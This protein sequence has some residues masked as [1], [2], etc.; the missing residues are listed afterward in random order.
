[1]RRR[2]AR[3]M[4]LT[5]RQASGDRSPMPPEFVDSIWRHWDKGTTRAILA[6]YR[7]ADP[8]RLAAAGK[9]LGRLDCPALVL[10]GDRDPY[11]PAGSPPP[12]ADALPKLE[13][14]ARPSRRPLA[15]DRRPELIDQ[16]LDFLTDSALGGMDR[17]PSNGGTRC[18]SMTSRC[19]AQ[20]HPACRTTPFLPP[21]T[22]DYNC[23]VSRA[24]PASAEAA[25]GWGD[26]GRQLGILV[27]VDVAYELVRGIADGQRADGDR[28]RRTGDRLRA[29]DPHLLRAQPA[30][31]LP[32]RPLADRRR[33][34]ALPQRPVLDRARLPDLALPL[35]QRVLLLRPQHVRRL[36]GP[37]SGRLH[38]LPD[39]AAADVP[40]ARL[41]RHDRRL[42]QRQPRLDPGEDLHQPL[43]GGAEHA[44]RLRR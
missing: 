23:A 6:L 31:L 20:G 4:A 15:L 17:R 19:P 27:L 2:P 25:Q 21:L 13:L 5:L 10:W 22:R 36:D 11:M 38:A 34:P 12:Y 28:P 14:E 42:L 35:P 30:G 3:R 44:L 41:R 26:A 9:D 39:R 37:G 43:R 40:A 8:D 32:A 29:L 24:S 1:M 33:Q 16:V 7:H 18:R